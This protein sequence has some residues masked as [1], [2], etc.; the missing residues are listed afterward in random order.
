MDCGNKLPS[1]N[2]EISDTKIIKRDLAV[3]INEFQDLLSV[4]SGVEQFA[5]QSKRKD[6]V[7]PSWEDIE[8][9]Q[10]RL[11]PSWETTVNKWHARVHFGSEKV[12]SK[13]KVFN[14]TIWEQV[15][16]IFILRFYVESFPLTSFHRYPNRT[17]D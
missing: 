3:L 1:F 11:R 14:Q 13:L 12:K 16:T 9:C 6:A 5:R 8:H 2:T 10:K 17:V 7:G 15:R 4:Q